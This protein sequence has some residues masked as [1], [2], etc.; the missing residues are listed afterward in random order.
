MDIIGPLK[1]LYVNRFAQIHGKVPDYYI[2]EVKEAQ[3]FSIVRTYSGSIRLLI[4]DLEDPMMNWI[5]GN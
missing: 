5:N 3:R 2:H 1:N 4:L